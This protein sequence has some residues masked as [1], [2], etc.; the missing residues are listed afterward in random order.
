M[1]CLMAVAF[2]GCSTEMGYPKTPYTS[3]NVSLT[4]KKGE[5]TQQQVLEA[6]GAPNIVTQDAEGNSVWTYQTNATVTRDAANA[7]YWNIILAGGSYRDSGF[8]RSQKTMTIIITFKDKVVS[9]F[10]S[11]STS[12]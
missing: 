8:M 10:K 7:N 1:L 9:N 5:T 4:L 3:G 12:F 11:L 2:A 6:F